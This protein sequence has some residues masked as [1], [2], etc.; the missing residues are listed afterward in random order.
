MPNGEDEKMSP[1]PT[2]Q[3]PNSPTPQLPNSPNEPN[4]KNRTLWTGDNLDIMRGMNAESV[5]LIYLDPPFNSKHNYAAPV[6][7]PSAGAEFKDTWTLSDIKVEWHGLIAEESPAL[8]NVINAAMTQSDKAYLIYM[9]PRILEMKRVLKDTGSIYLHCD[10]TMSHYIKLMMDAILGRKNFRNEIVWCYSKRARGAKAIA[11]HFPRNNDVILFYSKSKSNKRIYNKQTVIEKILFSESEYRI[12]EN[13]KCYRTAPRGDYTDESIEQLK[14]EGRVYVTR[15][16]NIRIKY[17]EEYDGE[18]VHERQILG[19]VWDDIPDMMH[20]P[21]KEKMNYPTQK[22]IALLDRIVRASSGPGGI[23]L[24]PFCG[25]ATACIAAEQNTRD[26][27]GID[28]SPKA[29][30]LVNI[31]MRKELG[32]FGQAIHRTDIPQ[33]TDILELPNYRTHKHTLY[34]K[35]EGICNG[36][37]HHFPF[38]NFTIDHIVPQSRGGQDDI[39]N[40]QLLCGACN[41][42]KGTGTMPELLSKLKSIKISA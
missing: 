36:C 5:D 19:N 30:E 14:K 12:D 8:Y 21:R 32:L 34:G 3:L 41:S 7:S 15:N 27:V 1:P 33:R 16:G 25:C 24:D 39:D 38:R 22:S 23:V 11:R 6:G 42:M 2:P 9:A 18:F 20:T 13:G 40:L 4:W 35:Q 31:R 29:Y 37:K 26:W 17:F 10:P 28:I